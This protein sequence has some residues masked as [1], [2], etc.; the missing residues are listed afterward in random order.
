MIIFRDFLIRF[1]NVD[2]FYYLR[3]ARLSCICQ[4]PPLGIEPSPTGFGGPSAPSASD[5]QAVLHHAQDVGGGY[6]RLKVLLYSRD[7]LDSRENL[8]LLCI[9][10]RIETA[11]SREDILLT[12]LAATLA[13]PVKALRQSIERTPGGT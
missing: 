1:V 9:G 8:T 4:A 11:S 3:P 6:P 5:L 2:K 10:D 7:S 12:A 13:E